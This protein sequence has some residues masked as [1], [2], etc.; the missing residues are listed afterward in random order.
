MD[1]NVEAASLYFA[2]EGLAALLGPSLTVLLVGRL[3]SA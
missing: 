1:K 3:F 2:Y